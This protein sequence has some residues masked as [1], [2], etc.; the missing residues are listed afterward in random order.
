[1][2]ANKYNRQE[3]VELLESRRT[4]RHEMLK[5]K[6]VLAD[7]FLKVKQGKVFEYFKFDA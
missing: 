6:K 4:I 3:R 1:M 2:I 7:K 5:S